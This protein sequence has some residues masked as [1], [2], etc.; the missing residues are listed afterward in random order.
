MPAT[1]T[2]AELPLHSASVSPD[3]PG[4]AVD[5]I[6][7]DNPE[8]PGVIIADHQNHVVGVVE[9]AAFLAQLSRRFGKSLYLKRPISTLLGRV[10]GS[11]TVIDANTPLAEA[12]HLVLSRPAERRLLPL[13][14][15]FADGRKALVHPDTVLRAMCRLLEATVAELQRTQEHLVEARKLAALGDVVAGIAHEINTPIGNALTCASH[16]AVSATEIAARLDSG[17]L[18]KSELTRFL[19]AA[20]EDAELISA[21]LT[22]AADLIR[23]FK[24]VAVDERSEA[25]RCF[26][27]KV[28]LQDIVANLRPRLKHTPHTVV[29]N[30]PPDLEI[31]SYPGAVSQ[32]VTN[33]ILN[34]LDHAFDGDRPG[35]VFI[36]V[37]ALDGDVEIKVR[38]DGRGIKPEDLPHIFERFFTTKGH[39]GGTGLGLFIVESLVR[40]KLNGDISCESTLGVGTTFTIRM[41]RVVTCAPASS[42]VAVA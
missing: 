23:G 11:P 1:P 25:R 16:I 8:L 20:R 4:A 26:A 21:N 33:L 41:P 42:T 40:G 31:D 28:Y 22:V 13:V 5:Q 10:D 36:D 34:A 14:V 30:C 17:A 27:L 9:R 38:D 39:L 3:T 24:Q 32:V 29:I 35:H 12:A 2:L 6:F 15:T 19:A 37:R 7:R 18:K